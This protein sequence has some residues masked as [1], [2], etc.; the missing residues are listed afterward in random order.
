M[1][2]SYSLFD[3][4]LLSPVPLTTYSV[5]LILPSQFTRLTHTN[6]PRA[7]QLPAGNRRGHKKPAERFAQNPGLTG[8]S[9]H[10]RVSASQGTG[11]S[12]AVGSRKGK[13]PNPESRGLN[14]DN[15]PRATECSPSGKPRGGKP[16]VAIPEVPGWRP[17]GGTDLGDSSAPAA[18]KRLPQFPRP[19]A[20]DGPDS[21]SCA[22]APCPE[23]GLSLLSRA[24]LTEPSPL[25][26]SQVS[27]PTETLRAHAV[28]QPASQS[29]THARR[30]SWAAQRA[31]LREPS[32]SPPHA[33]GRARSATQPS[34]HLCR[35]FP[36]TGL[37]PA[38]GSLRA[39][40]I[41]KGPAPKAVHLRSS[42]CETELRVNFVKSQCGCAFEV[43][44]KK[45]LLQQLR[46]QR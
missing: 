21:C 34:L 35:A 18:R 4:L 14:S 27:T 10:L 11:S 12:R 23:P 37:Q 36:A 32:T 9:S 42:T 38:R 17:S 31:L 20:L 24:E 29:C 2:K 39:P 6:I 45:G 40:E 43:L 44:N 26:G 25:R 7:I 28:R 19:G 13:G 3:C 1:G 22:R 15:K 16:R 41:L 8:G 30:S 5:F 33:L 46:H